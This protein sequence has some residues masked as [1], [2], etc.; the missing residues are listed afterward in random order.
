MAGGGG[1]IRTHGALRHAGFQ[2]RCIRPLC[3]PSNSP[4]HNKLG[5]T[6]NS[7]LFVY[8]TFRAGTKPQRQGTREAMKSSHSPEDKGYRIHRQKTNVK[9][10]TYRPEHRRPG[11]QRA[12]GKTAPGV[13]DRCPGSILLRLHPESS[14]VALDFTAEERKSL[15]ARAPVEG[16]WFCRFTHGS[17]SQE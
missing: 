5:R 2:D 11:N 10:R 15:I 14:S 1:G 17:G 6:S 16:K 4:V 9:G 8:A 13:R 7:T 12:R 3:H